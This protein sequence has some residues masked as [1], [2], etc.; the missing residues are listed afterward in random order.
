MSEITPPPA[1]GHV[2]VFGKC[3]SCGERDLYLDAWWVRDV[4]CPLAEETAASGRRP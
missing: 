2:A 3:P 4:G 1:F